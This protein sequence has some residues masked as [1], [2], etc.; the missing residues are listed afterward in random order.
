MTFACP[1]IP[2]TAT[3]KATKPLPAVDPK[4][5]DEC[6]AKNPKFGSGQVGKTK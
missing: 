1:S 6:R 3:K 2:S 5:V 4:V